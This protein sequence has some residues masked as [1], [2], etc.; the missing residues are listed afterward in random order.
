MNRPDTLQEMES[1]LASI[2]EAIE[3]HT[4]TSQASGPVHDH[5]HAQ[6]TQ[7]GSAAD[8]QWTEDES[9]ILWADDVTAAQARTATSEAHVSPRSSSY[10]HHA[11]PG[12]DDVPAMGARQRP[13]MDMHEASPAPGVRR[14]SLMQEGGDDRLAAT[15]MRHG[16][17]D[18]TA[19]TAAD[20]TGNRGATRPAWA[21][22]SAGAAE[23]GSVPAAPVA[24]SAARQGTARR[25]ANL[26]LVKTD[27]P[28]PPSTRRPAQREESPSA[29][30]AP[31]FLSRE[32]QERVR[33]AMS[34]QERIE[35]AKRALGGEQALR[36][37]VIDI[38]E[39]IIAQWLNEH[40]AEIVE[41][42]V[43]MEIARLREGS[44]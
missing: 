10:G 29:S 30:V 12:H 36:Q 33:A 1:L 21:M 35:A 38:V 13:A 26:R 3:T 44:D 8:W 23:A 18:A 40:L 43:A 32:V 27:A 37:L 24:P 34:R 22:S 16:S 2:R 42:R 41:R 5:H 25:T 19:E 17:A 39:P 9:D 15:R 7:S 11:D 20:T 28:V 31:S 6:V 14:R 4:E